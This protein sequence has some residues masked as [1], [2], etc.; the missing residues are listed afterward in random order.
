MFVNPIMTQT[1]LNCKGT[2]LMLDT[3]IVMGI[4][5]VTPD[6]FYS[7]SRISNFESL[8]LQ[9]EK[10]LQDGARILDIGGL[11]SRPGSEE[12]TIQEEIDRVVPVLIELKKSFPSAILSIDT[13]RSEVAKVALSNG[14]AIINDISGGDV[15]E[16][17][18]AI[19][20]QYQAPYICMHMQGMPKTM[21]QN[22]VYENV[23]HDVMNYFISKLNIFKKYNLHDV[24][25]D[26]GFG[27]GKTVEH[28]YQL[29]NGLN[30]FSIFEKPILAGISR[31]SMICKP[32]SCSPENALNGTTAL[33]MI[34]LQQGANILRAHDVKEAI[35]CIQ[36]HKMLKEN[37]V[38][39]QTK[40]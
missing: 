40:L 20:S 35:E 17:I 5:N 33:H 27:F 26:V 7:K 1:T 9:A 6:S 24:I 22:P 25:L 37:K 13:Y 30:L 2:L 39:T 23:V 21:Q 14:A 15:D 3:P 4:I 10:M 19:A 38:S 34:A 8:Q 31:K 28:N 11:S 29:L 18:L 36:L 12:I 32:L 16:S